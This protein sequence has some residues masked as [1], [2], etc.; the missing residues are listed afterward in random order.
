MSGLVELNALL[1][2]LSPVLQEGEF[3]F[4]TC[5]QASLPRLGEIHPVGTFC[6]AEGITLILPRKEADTLGLSY[7]SVFCMITLSVHSSLQAVGLTAA[8]STALAKHGISANV[9]AAYFYDHVFV[10]KHCA[11]SSLKVLR[12][13]SESL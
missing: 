2:S 5:S 12:A 7:D 6:E 9:V 1:K 8:V 13:L 3:V 11:Q 10:P 4:C